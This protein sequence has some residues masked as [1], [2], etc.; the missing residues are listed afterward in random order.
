MKK[1]L[2]QFA[3]FLVPIVVLA[4]LG[5]AFLSQ[6]LKKSNNF[7]KGEMCVWNDL[8]DKKVNS[9]II[10][11]GSSRAWVQIDTPMM[12]DSLH[13]SVYNLGIDGHNFWMQ[14]YRFQLAMQQP[15]KPKVVIQSIDIFTL[16]KREDL[17]YQEQF[18]PY[19][20]QHPE[21]EKITSQFLGFDYWDYRIPLMRYYGKG[22]AVTEAFKMFFGGKNEISRERGYQGQVK[23]WSNELDQAKARLKSFT[24]KLEPP[25]IAL[26]EK[27]LQYCKDNGIQM[28][29]VYTPEYVV[30][31][32]FISNR[33]EMIGLYEH[34]SKK[35]GIP[36]LDYS[37][38]PISHD[39]GYFYNALHM[40]KL[41]AEAFTARF[42]KDFQKLNLRY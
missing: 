15:V 26:F 25:T 23:P 13:T 16:T 27:Y 9:E 35:Y 18:L 14:D 21:L 28:V 39:R 10:V 5:D 11:M 42:I 29:F 30:G 17:F 12:T 33:K 22:G 24:V 37:N 34:F 2:L 19:M 7:V 36:F 3:L 20:M 31:Q 8:Y 4:Y 38:D 41:G 1:F 6:N 40:N 32:E